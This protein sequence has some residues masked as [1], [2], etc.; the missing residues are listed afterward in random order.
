MKGANRV[1]GS[2]G[3]GFVRGGAA[4]ALDEGAADKRR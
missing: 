4:N 1:A 2:A 3:R